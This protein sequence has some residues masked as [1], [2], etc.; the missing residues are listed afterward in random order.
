M[1][2]MF[3][4]KLRNI[5]YSLLL[6]GVW[7]SI[8]LIIGARSNSNSGNISVIYIWV[9]FTSL[10]SGAA[11]LILIILRAF[12]IIDK[13]RNFIY[14]FF[15]TTN[16]ALALCGI[17]FYLSGKINTIGLHDLL[18]NLLIGVVIIADIY[19]FE[20]IFHKKTA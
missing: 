16:F 14:S 2:P 11:G 9:K 7:T 12:S 8:I 20:S 19:L 5:S 15:G 3:S 17:G 10:I 1:N 4:R 13:N 18:P 6:L